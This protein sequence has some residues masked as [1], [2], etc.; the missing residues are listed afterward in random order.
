[1]D[2]ITFIVLNCKC[3]KESSEEDIH[4]LGSVDAVSGFRA[5]VMS[6]YYICCIV[7]EEITELWGSPNTIIRIIYVHI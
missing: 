2:T 5:D 1:M 6:P 7:V 4:T 3:Q